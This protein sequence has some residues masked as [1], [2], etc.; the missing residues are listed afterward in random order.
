MATLVT[1]SLGALAKSPCASGNWT[2]GRQYRELCYS[3]IVPLYGTEALTGGR[4][5]FIDRCP[6]GGS[7]Q[8]DEYPVLTMYL[9][10]LAAWMSGGY[11]PFFYVNAFLLGLA[12]FAVAW[13]LYEMVGER[14]LYFAIAPTLFIYAFVNWDLLAVALATGATLAYLR[15][16]DVLAG[17]LIG[18][19]AA[20]KFYP[21]LLLVPFVAGRLRERRAGGATSL[22]VWGGVTYGAVNLPFV[23]VS[24][25]AW[26]TF[27]RFNSS[28]LVDW[29]SVWFVAC[30]RLHGGTGCSWSPRLIDA[31]SLV[32]FAG[33]SA[34]VWLV[35]RARDPDF[36]RWTFGFPLLVAFLLANKVYSPQYGLWL[37]PWF[38]LSLPSPWLFG[39]F[40]LTDVAV[41]ITRFSWFGRFSRDLGSA[42]FVGYGGVPIG[43]FQVALMARAAVLV[44]C[45]AVWALRVKEPTSPAVGAALAA[46]A[47]T[48]G[49]G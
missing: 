44:A 11:G 4:L 37:L 29:D 2:D 19:G 5:P 27:F 46:P 21:A 43:A 24:F 6:A 30:Q 7:S 26:S 31:L 18:L 48:G 35:R 3:D 16:R 12:A 17:V 15:R 42:A 14:A 38:A 47:P 13:G 10:R 39:A 23:L 40:E 20:A 1:L 28:R 36:P 49:S 8:C 32:V 41:F 9:M 33:L 25:R 45:L 34:L 22:V